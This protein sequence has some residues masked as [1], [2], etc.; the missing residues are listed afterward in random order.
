MT[1]D[2]DYLYMLPQ[3][4]WLVIYCLFICMLP[5]CQLSFVEPNTK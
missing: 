4:E 2:N 1:G 5:I 3:E